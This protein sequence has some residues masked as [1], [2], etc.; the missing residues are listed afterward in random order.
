LFRIKGEVPVKEKV[1]HPCTVMQGRL[2]SLP[3]MN[4]KNNPNV[5][6][7]MGSIRLSANLNI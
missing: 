2:C 7:Y 6:G 4:T 1:A 3:S 5:K